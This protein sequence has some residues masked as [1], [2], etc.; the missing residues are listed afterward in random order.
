MCCSHRLHMKQACAPWPI[1]C[2]PGVAIRTLSLFFFL[3][4]QPLSDVWWLSTNRHRLPTNR[5]RLPT[6]RHRLPTN[7]HRLH[8]NR[9]RLHTN[10]HR[11][12]TN[13]HRLHT[14]RHRLPTNRHWLPT[15]RHRLHTNCHRLHTKRHRLPTNRHQLPTVRHH[16][17]YWTL[18]V[19]F[20]SL[21]WQ[22]LV[23]TKGLAGPEAG[24]AQQMRSGATRAC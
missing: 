9:H 2:L 6:N 3:L 17:A 21:L 13:R 14:N 16:R 7:R 15:N 8:T 24:A 19:F 11:L 12:P 20:F 1:E 5:H 10:R 22:P 4:R 18:R 23:S